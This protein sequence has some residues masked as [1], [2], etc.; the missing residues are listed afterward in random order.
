MIAAA[1]NGGIHTLQRIGAAASPITAKKRKL[2]LIAH[3]DGGGARRVDALVCKTAAT[4]GWFAEAFAM[5]HV[6]RRQHAD[7]RWFVQV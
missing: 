5:V 3:S 4:P 7:D 1:T 2:H 6:G